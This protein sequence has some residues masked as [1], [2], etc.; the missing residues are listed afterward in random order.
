[1]DRA[2]VSLACIFPPFPG[3]RGLRPMWPSAL[4]SALALPPSSVSTARMTDAPK[5]ERSSSSALSRRVS[6]HMSVSRPETDASAER[7]SRSGLGA[8][9]VSPIS[10]RAAV[11]SA[12]PSSS[13]PMS[14]SSASS[15]SAALVLFFFFFFFFLDAGGGVGSFT[16]GGGSGSSSDS[17]GVSSSSSSSSSSPPS[18]AKALSGLDDA[19]APSSS[20]DDS[21]DTSDPPPKALCAAANRGS[22]CAR[23]IALADAMAVVCEADLCRPSRGTFTVGRLSTGD[24]MID[25]ATH[26][27]ILTICAACAKNSNAVSVS[28]HFHPPDSPVS[29][30]LF[31]R[32]D[33]THRRT[34]P[35]GAGGNIEPDN[36]RVVGMES[37]CDCQRVR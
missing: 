26:A 19:R 1:M 33:G 18:R 22:P 2:F 24:L 20:L 14:A 31:R 15:S 11:I 16:T 4:A 5:M 13:S 35:R 10:L 17:S 7:A 30:S 34:A 27:G 21:S 29:A 3:A 6:T 36:E 28:G 9:I 25:Q 32:T 12:M 23:F 8:G 37:P